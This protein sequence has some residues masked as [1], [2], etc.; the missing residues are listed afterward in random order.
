[1]FWNF[2]STENG[3]FAK[4]SCGGMTSTASPRTLVREATRS[5]PSEDIAFG[6]LRLLRSGEYRQFLVLTLRSYSGP[7]QQ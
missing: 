1:M 2:K 3:R 5:R 7:R 6:R 4:T